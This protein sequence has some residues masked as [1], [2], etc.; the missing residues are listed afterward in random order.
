[1]LPRVCLLTVA[2]TADK[3]CR[4]R[5]GKA[6]LRFS[7]LTFRTSLLVELQG[8]FLLESP[9]RGKSKSVIWPSHIWI[10]LLVRRL[11]L[12]FLIWR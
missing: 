1:M 9:V 3:Y 6:L 4:F 5:P 7:I 11:N 2:H 8:K 10:A 12:F